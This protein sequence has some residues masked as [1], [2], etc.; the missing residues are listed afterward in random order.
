MKSKSKFISPGVYIRE[1]A[2]KNWVK[3]IRRRSKIKNIFKM[4]TNEQSLDAL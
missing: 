2:S 1:P 4:K 3:T